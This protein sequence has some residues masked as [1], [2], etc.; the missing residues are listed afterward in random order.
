[1]RCVRCGMVNREGAKFC[2]Q[3]GG[4]LGGRVCSRCGAVMGA[5]ARFCGRCGTE[6]GEPVVSVGEAGTPWEA[7]GEE[8]QKRWVW[9]VGVG[10]VGAIVLLL[11][12]R[13]RPPAVYIDKGVCPGEG[14][15]Y[16]DEVFVVLKPTVA[17]TFPS[18]KSA[19]LFELIPGERV[20]AL[21]SEVHT[22]AGRFVVKR[23]Y[24]KYRPGDVIWVYTYLG[25][26]SFKVWYRGKMYVENLSFSPWGGASGKRCE[27]DEDCWGELEKGLEMTWWLKVKN[28]EGREGW[29]QAHDNLMQLCSEL[30][31]RPC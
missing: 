8:R 7:K 22:V 28:R 21:D 5:E 20:T 25:E 16:K 30:G 3:C 31:G 12:S 13:W 27:E 1:M 29:V 24:K 10:A 6:L 19:R 18:V 26:G 11:W 9:I 15:S 4:S 14:C 17:Y 2:V 23:H